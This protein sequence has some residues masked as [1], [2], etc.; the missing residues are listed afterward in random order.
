MNEMRVQERAD[1]V[2]PS[3]AEMQ[4]AL[5]RLGEVHLGRPG[6]SFAGSLLS[7]AW[8]TQSL[9]YLITGLW[10]LLHRRS[11]QAVTGPKI[12]WWLVKTVGTL[13]AVIGSVLGLGW[14]R[15][16]EESGG[17]PRPETVLLAVGSA[18]GLAAVDIA[19]AGARRRIRPVYLLDAIAEV[20]LAAAWLYGWWGVKQGNS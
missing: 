13:I 8:L 19:Y 3:F 16:G 4:N 7:A 15:R 12:D 10:P 2:T 6:F 17:A 5:P 9:F 11:F 18:A 20:A 14:L 1:Y